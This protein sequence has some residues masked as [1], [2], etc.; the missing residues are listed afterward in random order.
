[1]QKCNEA[2]RLWNEFRLNLHKKVK[3][4]EKIN[5]RTALG[6]GKCDGH[7]DMGTRKSVI[8]C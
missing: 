6:R 7:V 8:R 5:V 4:R 1:M 2:A 3:V